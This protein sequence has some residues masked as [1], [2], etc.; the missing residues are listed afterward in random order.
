MLSFARC[1][2][3]MLNL[4]HDWL[5]SFL[6]HV[7]AKIDRVSFGLLTPE[8]LK[9]ALQVSS[10]LRPTATN[11]LFYFCGVPTHPDAVFFLKVLL[12]WGEACCYNLLFPCSGQGITTMGFLYYP[13]STVSI[14]TLLYLKWTHL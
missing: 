11:W 7:L 10:V 9:R 14:N 8:D 5:R 3:Q 4:T 12:V 1:P 13:I 2:L 6:P